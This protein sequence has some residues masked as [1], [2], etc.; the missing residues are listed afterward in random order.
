LEKLC[1]IKD[2]VGKDNISDFATNLIKEFL[3]EYTQTFAQKHID[4]KLRDTF[5][6]PRTRFNYETETWEE[7]T[8]DLP[9]LKGDFI[10][11]TPKNLLTKD[12]TWI[13]RKD[14]LEDFDRIPTAITNE[15]L[16][17]QTNNYFRSILIPDPKRK[18]E[19]TKQERMAA[20]FETI[21]QF[22]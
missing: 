9:K 16:R 3:L 19:P 6:I 12:E 2:G 11:L 18:K 10:I 20:A 22:P 5:R 7:R 4:K 8:F 21:R 13:N 15:Q 14:L 1:L 17:F